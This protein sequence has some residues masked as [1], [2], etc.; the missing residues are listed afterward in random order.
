MA[1]DKTSS[2]DTMSVKDAAKVLDLS[3]VRVLGLYKT[4]QLTGTKGKVEGTDI[5]QVRLDRASVENYQAT[6]RTRNGLRAMVVKLDASDMAE[7]EK[8]C[9]AHGWTLR[10]K[11]AKREDADEIDETEDVNAA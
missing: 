8:I 2:G 4:G 1:T 9:A 11:N 7:L 10:A 3:R 5:P 6:P